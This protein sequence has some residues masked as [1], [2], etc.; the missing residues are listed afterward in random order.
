M[1]ASLLLCSVLKWENKTLSDGNEKKKFSEMYWRDKL[2]IAVAELSDVSH[3]TD[4]DFL[5]PLSRTLG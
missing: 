1:Y 4:L 5:L 3:R 2:Q